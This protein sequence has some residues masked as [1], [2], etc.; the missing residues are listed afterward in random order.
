MAKSMTKKERSEM[1]HN[2]LW[3]NLSNQYET[4]LINLG[5]VHTCALSL[6]SAIDLCF[7]LAPGEDEIKN[8]MDDVFEKVKQR[9]KEDTN[10]DNT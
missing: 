9:Y 1:A 5:P 2:C 8:L 3:T 7:Q 4:A 10:N 6:D